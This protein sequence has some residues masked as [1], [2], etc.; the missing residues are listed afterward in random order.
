MN[1]SAIT[2]NLWLIVVA[3]GPILLAVLIAIAL[4]RRTK[5]S[6]AEKAATERATAALYDPKDRNLPPD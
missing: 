6:P 4:M 2:E 5:R 1:T 3:G